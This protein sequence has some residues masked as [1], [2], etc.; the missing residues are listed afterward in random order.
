MSTPADLPPPTGPP[1]PPP[2]GPLLP[3]PNGLAL[4]PPAA[5]VVERAHPLT[6][7]IRGWI[8]AGVILYNAVRDWVEGEGDDVLGVAPILG[9]VIV[10]GFV[11]G[12][13][14]WWFTRFVIDDTEVRV[15]TGFVFR[16]SRR[17]TFSRIQAVDLAQPLLARLFRLA[18][19]RVEVAGGGGDSRVSLRYLPIA[20]AEAMRVDLLRRA[21]GSADPA[22]AKD[23]TS[24]SGALH[25]GE[26]VLLRIP[27]ARLIGAAV[28]SLEFFGAVLWAAACLVPWLLFDVRWL[29]PLA[30]PAAFGVFATVRSRIFAE[31]KFTLS[32]THDTVRIRRGLT[33]VAAQSIAAERIQGVSV[34]QPLT[35]R[36]IGWWRV[37]MTVAGYGGG[38][39]SGTESS[40]TLLP[41]GSIQDVAAVLTVALGSRPDLAPRWEPVSHNARW[42][43]PIGRRGL[44]WHLSDDVF[45]TRRGV[46]H[47]VIA[48][49]PT[50]RIQSVGTTQGPVQRRLGMV[51]VKA[52]LPPGPVDVTAW[53][54]DATAGLAL[55]TRLADSVGQK[56][57]TP[58]PGRH[59]AE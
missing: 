48:I 41:V 10:L 15:D 19:V 40:T 2:S 43:E 22:S 52:H 51:D 35:W 47:K 45:A 36:R 37:Q 18:E 39:D 34:S 32:S 20:R 6:P 1:L 26:Q 17:V 44:G 31:Y 29:T 27:L 11:G 13:L 3:P 42:L 12:A 54:L 21:R 56:V 57:A 33:D 9:V 46:V 24:P 50:A 16:Q 53:F 58:P 23:T 38:A 49:V 30:L 7:F 14:S 25:D 59:T 8:V 55:A 28:L 4:P 5:K